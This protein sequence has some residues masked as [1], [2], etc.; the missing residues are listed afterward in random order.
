MEE[1]R[2]VLDHI[3]PLLL[4]S[5]LHWVLAI[6][7]LQ[8]LKNRERVLGGWKWVWAVLIASVAFFGSLLYMLC[9]PGIFVD[10]QRK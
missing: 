8:D 3:F 10:I 1:V 7:L 6:M 4:M 5:M 2:W 9:H